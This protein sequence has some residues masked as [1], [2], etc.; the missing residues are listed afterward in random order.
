MIGKNLRKLM[1]QL[2]LKFCM[3]K[4][5]SNHEK[6][7]LYYMILNRKGHEANIHVFFISMTFVS[8]YRLSFGDFLSIC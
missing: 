6:Q 8:I 2:L 3:L 4:K 5:N 1:Q 7:V